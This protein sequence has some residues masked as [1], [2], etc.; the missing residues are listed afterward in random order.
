M[1]KKITIVADENIPKLDELLGDVADIIYLPGRSISAEDLIDADALLIRSITRVNEALLAQT[2][3]SF[4]GS[5]TIGTDHV[6]IEYLSSRNIQFSNAPGCNAAAVVDYVLTAMFSFCSDVDYWKQKTVGIIGLGQ[7]GGRLQKRLD[8]IGI[9]SKS[10]D[11]FK[12]E[13]HDSFDQVLA[14]DVVSL[15]VPLTLC[16]EHKTHHLISQDKLERFSEDTLL[17]NTSRGPVI[18]NKALLERLNTTPFHV[19]LDVYEEEPKPDIALLDAVDIATS[20]IA[21]YS[22]HGKI[23]G[24]MQVVEALYAHFSVSNPLPDL[25]SELV[26]TVEI[27][28]SDCVGV[29]LLSSYDIALDSQSFIDKYRDQQTDAE[30]SF[31]FDTYRKN[32]QVRYEWSYL[33]VVASDDVVDISKALGFR[34]K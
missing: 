25:L 11:P 16:G 24:S 6:D 19:V 2:N 7:V 9:K 8:Q 13:A 22:L 30:K 33:N 15:H 32:Y 26:D 23:R 1:N 28:Q 31:A 4:V 18:D 27:G 29:L 12:E 34:G 20:H 5:C 17:I 10:Y 3:L 21:G 14:C